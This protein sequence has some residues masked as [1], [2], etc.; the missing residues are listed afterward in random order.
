V[1]AQALLD[2]QA[3]PCKQ[4]EWWWVGGGVGGGWG[5]SEGARINKSAGIKPEVPCCPGQG[6]R[7]AAALL[8]LPAAGCRGCGAG[9][10][11]SWCSSA[12]PARC[13]APLSR[14]AGTSRRGATCTAWPATRQ[15]LHDIAGQLSMARRSMVGCQQATPQASIT[16]AGQAAA[17]AHV[18][19]CHPSACPPAPATITACPTKPRGTR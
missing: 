1:A 3:Q 10:A 18:A 5:G 7:D 9:G 15:W 6:E 14:G 12:G 11:C 8:T 17:A 13:A 19:T 4:Q 2:F 16:T